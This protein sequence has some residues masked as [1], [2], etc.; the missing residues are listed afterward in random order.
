ML[1]LLQKFN[2][3]VENI[4][5]NETLKYL[6]DTL[7]KDGVKVVYEKAANFDPDNPK[8]TR[9]MLGTFKR[10][11]LF[12]FPGVILKQTEDNKFKVLSVPPSP[13]VTQY[14]SKYL[15]KHFG[16]DT[17]IIK[18]N[19]GTT[20]TLYYFNDKW[21]IS[22]HR[23]FEVNTYNWMAQKTYQ[24]VIGEVLSEYPNF[25]YD[26]LDTNKCYTF[27]FNHSDFHPF[28]ENSTI[29]TKAKVRAWFIQSVD[30]IM[31]NESD[32]SCVSFEEDIGLPIQERVTF[33]HLKYLFQN[34]NSA[35]TNYLNT[36]EVNYGYLIKIGIKQFLVEST[37]LKH[38]RHIFYSNKFNKLDKVFDKRNYIIV[39]SF[40]DA[41][42]HTIFK[43]LFPQY[44]EQFDMLEK[45]V[46]SLVY[47]ILLV[48][49]ASNEG[50][51][52]KHETIVDVVA[53]EM[54]D[55]ITK[56]ITLSKRNENDV[57]N[58]I[59]SYIYDTKFTDLIYKLAFR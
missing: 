54:Y 1:S 49:K 52:T 28:R 24:D 50:K 3:F 2:S 59:Y 35:Y 29:D 30:L 38:I 13:P 31:F 42:K 33:P 21:V 55:Q 37:L 46:D 12:D 6:H 4:P 43:K 10:S 56:T 57:T 18:A 58:L 39:H 7:G 8:Y 48:I 32:P 47:A 9:L 40:L 44:I 26:K 22:T 23:G 17:E 16:K 27:G 5:S 15:Y 25:S 19:D 51:E 11:C 45:N 34:A 36:K 20:V 41:G 53:N 14:Q